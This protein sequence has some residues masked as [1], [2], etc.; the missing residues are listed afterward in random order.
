[1]YRDKRDKENKSFTE[2]LFSAKGI[3]VLIAVVML[4]I[5]GVSTLLM[6]PYTVEQGE[7]GIVKTWG[8]YSTIAEPGF[9]TKTPFA[10]NVETFNCRVRSVPMSESAGTSDLQ[11]VTTQVTLNY[12]IAPENVKDVYTQ[13]GQGIETNIIVPAI[14]EALKATTAKYTAEELISIRDIVKSAVD[15]NIRESLTK[16]GVTVDLVSI[17]DFAFSGPFQ[18]AIDAK[19]VAQQDA[20][21]AQNKLAQVQFESQQQVINAQAA[22][23]ATVTRAQAD[24]N[25]TII[26]A[27]AQAEYQRLVNSQLTSE[28]LQYMQIRAWA[29]GGSQVPYYYAGNSSYLPTLIIPTNGTSLP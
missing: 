24:A 27:Q 29:E 12:H 15:T 11:A 25:A 10:D 28:Y 22:A 13:F 1:M 19:M 2:K 16:F 6:V 9:H 8:Q 26:N 14:Q 18:A 20:L 21:A 3:I 7:V 17:T 5:V 23:T 4:A